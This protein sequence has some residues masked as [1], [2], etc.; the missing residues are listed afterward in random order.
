MKNSFITYITTKKINNYI[1]PPPLQIMLIRDY[2]KNNSILFSLPIEEFIFDN[3]H[4]ELLGI[5]NKK[6]KVDGIIMTSF[7]AL[8]TNINKLKSFFNYTMKN[9]IELHFVM[10]AVIINDNLDKLDEIIEMIQITQSINQWKSSI[11][12][13]LK[14]YKIV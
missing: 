2:C 9:N 13:V 1:I 6:D 14:K 5:M 3:C 7:F 12:E 8:P 10:E 11:A 4:I